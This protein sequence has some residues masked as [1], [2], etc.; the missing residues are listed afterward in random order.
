MWKPNL[1]QRTTG[2]PVT[3][4]NHGAMAHR[5]GVGGGKVV[6]GVLLGLLLTVL[7]AGSVIVSNR[8]TSLRSE[9]ASLESRREVLE[10]DSARLLTVWNQATAPSVVT[11][12]AEAELGLIVPDDPGLVLVQVDENSADV[13]PLRRWLANVGGGRDAEAGEVNPGFV[14]GSMVS[15]T[16]R[17]SQARGMD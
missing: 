7:L 13:N 6:S 5:R 11:A 12:R 2:A 9:I 4:A 17:S 15:L 10:A 1:D 3:Q 14:M 8:V 16:P